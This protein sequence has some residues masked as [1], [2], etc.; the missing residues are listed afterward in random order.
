MTSGIWKEVRLESWSDFK[1]WDVYHEISSDD[2]S[3]AWIETAIQCNSSVRA[4]AILEIN[5]NRYSDSIT[6]QNPDE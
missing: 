3:E 1:L 5:G 4:T 2:S 6:P